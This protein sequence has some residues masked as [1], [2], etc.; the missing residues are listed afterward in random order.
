MQAYLEPVF[1]YAKATPDEILERAGTLESMIS[2]SGKLVADANYRRDQFL[3]GAISET[4]KEALNIGGWP[5][6]VTNKKIDAMAIDYN[7]VCKWA[8]RVNRSATHCHQFC[9]TAISKI[10][11]EMKM[12][13]QRNY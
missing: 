5:A 4:I 8:D 10:K 1:N 6:L 11:E 13:N 2:Y 3:S 9:I 7:Y 12:N